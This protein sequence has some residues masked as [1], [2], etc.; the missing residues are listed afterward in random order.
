MGC[1]CGSLFWVEGY[2]GGAL[3]LLKGRQVNEIRNQSAK[4]EEKKN[5]VSSIL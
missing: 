3:Q 1:V 4:S 5:P 2:Q